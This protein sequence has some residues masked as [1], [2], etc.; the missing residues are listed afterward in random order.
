MPNTEPPIE[1]VEQAAAYKKEILAALPEG[2]T[3]EPLMTLYLTKNLKPT[4]IEKGR[5]NGISAVKYYPWGATTNSQW[6]YRDILEARDVLNT[7]EG[8]GRN[9]AWLAQ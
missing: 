8:V 2:T 4:E 9:P 6:G 7:M 5:E 3:F 1:T